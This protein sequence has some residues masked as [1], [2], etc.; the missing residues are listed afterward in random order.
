MDLLIS[1]LLALVIFACP[2]IAQ[3]SRNITI[4]VPN[5]TSYYQNTNELC[6]PT[7]WT[8]IITFFGA[9]YFA[10]AATIRRPP[11]NSTWI[12]LFYT[13][14]CLLFPICGLFFA[15]DPLLSFATFAPTNLQ[16]ATRAGA[17]VMVGRTADW[18]PADGDSIEY[19]VIISPRKQTAPQ[20]AGTHQGN[21]HVA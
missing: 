10:H 9:N 13:V 8:D 7:S 21:T 14:L 15:L 16:M 19:S 12:G 20:P 11:G 3:A 18:K 1:Y 17:L 5:G 4:A 6:F 2:A